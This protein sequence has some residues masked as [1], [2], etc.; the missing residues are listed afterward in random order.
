MPLPNNS[1]PAAYRRKTYF[2]GRESIVAGSRSAGL[3]RWKL[4][5][6]RVMSRNARDAAAYFGLPANRVVEL[7][8]QVQL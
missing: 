7:G 3:P 1:P 8:A 2:L 6:F 4:A 5:L